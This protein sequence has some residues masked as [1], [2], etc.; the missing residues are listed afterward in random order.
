MDGEVERPL[1]A[2]SQYWELWRRTKT[3]GQDGKHSLLLGNVAVCWNLWSK[4]R[5]LLVQS[6]LFC[7][8]DDTLYFIR[9]PLLRF[10]F[11]FQGINVGVRETRDIYWDRWGG[12]ILSW[13]EIFANRRGVIAASAS[14]SLIQSK[15]CPLP[16]PPSSTRWRMVAMPPSDMQL[17]LVP[18]LWH[19]LRRGMWDSVHISWP[20]NVGATPTQRRWKGCWQGWYVTQMH[21]ALMQARRQLGH[22]STLKLTSSTLCKVLTLELLTLPWDMKMKTEFKSN[23]GPPPPTTLSTFF[24]PHV[25]SSPPKISLVPRPWLPRSLI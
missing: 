15:Y 16:E 9:G 11:D 3:K 22:L 10:Y 14:A 1:I 7:Y 23:D 8:E 4:L 25:F 20:N 21:T 13:M 5:F 19:N 18:R 24:V 12:R 2:R 17:F 6:K